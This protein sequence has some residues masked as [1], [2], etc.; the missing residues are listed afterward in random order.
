MFM[1]ELAVGGA[2]WRGGLALNMD[3]T[4]PQA[5][6]LDWTKTGKG[7]WSPSIQLSQS[8]PQTQCYQAPQALWATD[9]AAPTTIHSWSGVW[10][11]G[12]LQIKLRLSDMVVGST[13]TYQAISPAQDLSFAEFGNWILNPLW[14]LSPQSSQSSEVVLYFSVAI[15]PYGPC[16]FGCPLDN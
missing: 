14:M 5:W 1:R 2:S 13:F 10:A 7:E 9:R 16:S 3:G 6:V 12:D 15:N 8:Y 4:L 11:I